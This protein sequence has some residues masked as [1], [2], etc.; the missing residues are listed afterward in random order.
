MSS[1]NHNSPIVNGVSDPEAIS[2]K[3][4]SKFS[5]TL[6]T[7]SQDMF[8][9]SDLL[10]YSTLCTDLLKNVV[11]HYLRA[12]SVFTFF[13]DASKAFD[14]V[15]HSILYQKLSHRGVP[16]LVVR[17]LYRWYSTQQLKVRWENFNF[18]KFGVSKGVRQ[19]AV[20]SPILFSIY[21]DSLGHF[22]TC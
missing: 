1:K 6:N 10:I 19:S 5:E 22:Q 9:E 15:K 21:L 14:L 3:L 2:N 17:F 13:L 11:S 12:S 7:H 8:V 20:L 16:N 4:S 18:N